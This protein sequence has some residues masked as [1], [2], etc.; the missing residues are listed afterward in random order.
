MNTAKQNNANGLI[1]AHHIEPRVH[2][3]SYSALKYE[4]GSDQQLQR[5]PLFSTEFRRHKI[6]RESTSAPKSCICGEYP[7]AV[8][9][10]KQPV[11]RVRSA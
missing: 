6:E 10:P 5:R 7:T 8:M 1:S 11:A 2:E 9:T 3:W 4:L